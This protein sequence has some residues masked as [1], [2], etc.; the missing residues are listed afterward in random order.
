MTD[1]AS[2]SRPPIPNSYWVIPGQFAAGEYPGDLHPAE[3]GARLRGLLAEGVSH[4]IDL[5]QDI[6][7]LQPYAGVL[8]EEARKLGVTA[9]HESH[10]I[11]DMSVPRTPEEMTGVLDAIDDALDSGEKVY[12]H[13][14]GGVG[15]T[16]TVVGC[17]LVRQ[18][19][20]GDE[21]LDQ[22][23]EWWQHVPKSWRNPRSPETERQ[24]DY[25]RNWNEGS[26]E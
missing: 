19:M 25:I 7:L 6:D 5:T 1:A 18:G 15:R 10:P 26:K 16:G 20:T 12:L 14:W 24:R 13:C 4:F 2:R 22:I 11:R 8:A 17:W 9:V 3:A 23:R 21:A